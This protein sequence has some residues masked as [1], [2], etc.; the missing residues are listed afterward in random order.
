MLKVET[1]QDLARLAALSEEWDR[2]DRALPLRLPF[3]SPLWALEWWRAFR[4][5][6]FS[7]SDQIHAYALRDGSGALVALAPTFV[8]SR[9]GRGPLRARELQFFGADPY[10]TEWRGLICA[11][12]RE[13]E[14]LAALIA[15]MER[16]KPAD[17]IQWRGIPAGVPPDALGSG[18]QRQPNMGTTVHY[19]ELPESWDALRA[20]LP[21]NIKE[22]LRKCY[23]SLAR[24][25][26]AFSLNVAASPEAAPAALDVFFRL[27][28]MRASAGETIGHPDVFAD[29]RAKNFLRAY[30]DGLA[31]RG[32]LRIF[33]LTIAGEIVASRIAFQFDDQIYMYFSG[34][35]L[36]WGKY[37]VMTTTVAEAMKWSIANKLRIFNLSTGNDVSKTRWRPKNV[38]FFGGYT[39]A[40]AGLSRLAFAALHRL[41]MN[42]RAA[43]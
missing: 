36:A 35:D 19:L 24:D 5:D 12:D 7:A 11:P 43:T 39:V 9:P 10:V 17:F 30:C 4:R 25:G 33:E 13:A 22:S 34:Y 37:S 16:E 20:S 1:I 2:L 21:R 32:Q 27:H 26:H 14:A 6:S 41:R 40:A 38:E 3:T 29:P 15:H 31:Q 18:F 28:A 42:R 8:T 23:N